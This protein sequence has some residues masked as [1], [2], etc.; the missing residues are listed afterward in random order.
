[1]EEL[2]NV[3][4]PQNNHLTE[5]IQLKGKWHSNFFKNKNP[6]VL[7]LGCGKGEYSVELSERYPNKNF[8]G[9][10]IKGNRMWKGATDSENNNFK[11]IAF[12]RIRIE[13]ILMCFA[14]DEVSEIWITFPDPQTKKKRQKKRLTHPEFLKKYSEILKDDGIIYLKT[15]S[16]FLY[17]Y[18]LGVIEGENHKLLDCTNDVYGTNQLRENMDVKTHYEK[19]F[20]AKGIPI[21]YIKFSLKL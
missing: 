11:N 15:D 1:M 16:M 19:M 4:Q 12:L 14:K 8:V 2:S 6:I 7:E 13:N 18:T 9:V 10:D 5:D 21:T 20:L 3:I 17:G